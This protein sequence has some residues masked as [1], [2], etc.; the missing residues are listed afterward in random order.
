LSDDRS[1]FLSLEF[2]AMKRLF[3]TLCCAAL[4]CG[5]VHLAYAGEDRGESDSSTNGDSG[6]QDSGEGHEGNTNS[7]GGSTQSSD[8]DDAGSQSLDRSSTQDQALE[9]VEHGQAVSLPLL[10]AF[11]AI[12]HPGQVL[13]VKLR[14][15]IFGYY[16]DVKVL[17]ASN[18]LLSFTLD[19]K[20][21][22]K[23]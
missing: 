23:R 9:A 4:V 17:D 1:L 10:F 12:H 8:N 3:V 22:E 20:T 15:S 6:D 7:N 2:V 16:Y 19:A 11:V 14:T 21:L 13:D 18:H 5:G